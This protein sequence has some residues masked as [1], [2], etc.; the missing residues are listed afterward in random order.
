MEFRL[1][2]FAEKVTFQG[3]GDQR[4]APDEYFAGEI[5]QEKADI[6][7]HAKMSEAILFPIREGTTRI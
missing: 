7:H 2:H 6:F 5:E 3:D 1:L 4:K